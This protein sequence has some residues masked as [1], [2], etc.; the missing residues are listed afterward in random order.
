MRVH[1]AQSLLELF[2]LYEIDCISNY[3]PGAI[4]SQFLIELLFAIDE[5]IIGHDIVII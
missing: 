5:N 2:K 3:L 4:S 1:F